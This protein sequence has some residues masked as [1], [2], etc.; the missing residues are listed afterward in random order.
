MSGFMLSVCSREVR[1]Q[2][3]ILHEVF[4]NGECGKPQREDYAT[5][6][7]YFKATAAYF[8]SKN[9]RSSSARSTGAITIDLDTITQTKII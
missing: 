7:E 3:E 2:H 6:Y 1:E 9:R 8:K 5:G 4:C